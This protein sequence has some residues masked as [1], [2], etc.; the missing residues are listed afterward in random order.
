MGIGLL[1]LIYGIVTML[2]AEG[3][4]AHHANSRL[5]GNILINGFFF[6][7]ISL[8]AVFYIAIQY[9]AEAAWS[10][11]FK[12]VFEATAAYLPIGAGVLVLV[13][14]VGSLHGHHLYHWMD[15]ELFDV[16]SEK[17]D[18]VIAGKEPYLNQMFFWA[19]VI[20]FI[21]VC[22]FF[23]R[24]FRK[25]SLEEDIVGGVQI[26][27]KNITSAA[28]FLV[29][30]GF[31]SSIAAWDWLMS[32]DAHWFSTLFGWYTFTGMWISGITFL[33]LLIIYLKKQGYL[34]Q[35]NRNHIHDMGKWMF[36]ISFLWCYMWF[37]QYMLIW[38]SNIPEEVT[39]YQARLG[40]YQWLFFGM[41]LINFAFPMLILMDRAAK[42]NYTLLVIVGILIF[43]GHW[44]DLYLMVTP[45]TMK[46]HHV[47]G[48]LEVGLFLGF[49]GLFINVVLRALTKA[50][51]MVK[52]HP[53]LEES[54]HLQQ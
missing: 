54:V 26:H 42:R 7:S 16:N 21:G 25:R 45:G 39:Y 1:T 28:I 43:I 12:R 27:K 20:L 51:L 9:A 14:L 11:V 47:N 24:K 31:T 4:D 36:A 8:I 37:F 48:I 5:W 38:Y 10:T 18:P 32:I 13:F 23:Q 33:T 17:Y 29:F 2:G 19:R 3:E 35:V 44:L 15:P 30:L 50:P 22:I 40:D 53:F 34:P 46:G 49:L 52:N 41:F 6:F